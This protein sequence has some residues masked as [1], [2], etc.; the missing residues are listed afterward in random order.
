MSANWMRLALVPIGPVVFIVTV[1]PVV[2]ISADVLLAAVA[3]MP[4]VPAVKLMTPPLPFNAVPV[5]APSSRTIL[6]APAVD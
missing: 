2:L 6:P 5:F 3:V 1:A 4:P